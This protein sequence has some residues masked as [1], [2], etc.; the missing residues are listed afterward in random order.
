LMPPAEAIVRH[1]EILG[2]MAAI[3]R[4]NQKVPPS[5]HRK[6]LHA[7]A[8]AANELLAK[9]GATADGDCDAMPRQVWQ[10]LRFAAEADAELIGGFRHNPPTQRGIGDH[11]FCDYQSDRQ[12]S[13]NVQA[14]AQLAAWAASAEDKAKA[15]IGRHDTGTWPAFPDDDPWTGDAVN[16]LLSGVCRIWTEVL[17]AQSFGLAH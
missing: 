11:K 14:V 15:Q 12:L 5:V 6:N 13:D 7:I 8:A 4:E 9:L 1:L 16:D 10:S 2:G 3:N 17:I